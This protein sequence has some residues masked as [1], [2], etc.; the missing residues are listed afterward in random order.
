MQV[1]YLKMHGAGNQIVIVDLRE[2]NL[3]P[4]SAEKLRRLGDDKTGPGFDQLMWVGPA[5]GNSTSASYRIFN[6]D[7]SECEQCGNGVRCVFWML[8][9]ESDQ[10]KSFAL[11]SPAGTIEAVVLDD[12]RIA[13]NMGP[14]NFDPRRVPFLAEAQA[15]QYPLEVAGT[16]INTFVLSMGN[17]HCVVQVSDVSATDVAGLGPAIEGHE[18]FPARTNVGFM[19]IRDRAN[20][21]LREYERGAGETL[22]C[23]TGAC[24]AVVA[25]QRLGQL[26][27][28]VTVQ[29]AGGQLVVSWCGETEGVWLTG[30]AELISEGTVD[31]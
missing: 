13:V 24:A 2:S 3:P 15:D 11:E 28:E 10:E 17:P 29:M 22:A 23:G 7:G 31:L 8:A 4:P 26:D 16:T 14:P 30:D 20:I 19:Q 18:R 6:S 1:A 25:G 5:K 12:G 9:R 27:D 21:A